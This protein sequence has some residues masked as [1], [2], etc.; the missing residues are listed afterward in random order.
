MRVLRLPTTLSHRMRTMFSNLHPTLSIQTTAIYVAVVLQTLPYAD[1]RCLDREEIDSSDV[2]FLHID[3]DI[4]Y[5]LEANQHYS[6]S[7]QDLN[8]NQP[9]KFS[10]FFRVEPNMLFPYSKQ[11]Q[12]VH[13]K[14]FD[15]FR[16]LKQLHSSCQKFEF[17]PEFQLAV[18]SH[19]KG[20]MLQT[21]ILVETFYWFQQ[22]QQIVLVDIFKQ[23]SFQVSVQPCIRIISGEH[24][25]V[26]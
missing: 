24:Y 23:T 2:G 18:K 25:K 3:S 14:V 22:A 20:I 4:C 26:C 13:R 9:P 11:L 8:S 19:P 17:I 10:P 7:T 6:E 1:F 5:R 16:G 12:V 21:V 15:N